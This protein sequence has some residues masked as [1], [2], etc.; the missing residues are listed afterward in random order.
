MDEFQQKVDD[1][2]E[3]IEQLRQSEQDLLKQIRTLRQVLST[4]KMY[5]EFQKALGRASYDE[6]K[7]KVI[8]FQHKRAK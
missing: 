7:R 2:N 4:P 6:S 3:L 1:Q 8:E 5:C